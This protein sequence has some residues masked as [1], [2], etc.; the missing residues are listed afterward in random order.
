MIYFSWQVV[1]E[2]IRGNSYT[3]DI[4]LDDISFTVGAANCIQRPYD[5]LP[6]GVTTSAP[7]LSTSSSV[8]PTTIG[9]FV[10]ISIRIEQ[11]KK[12]TKKNK[13]N[14]CYHK[15][16]WS[17]GKSEVLRPFLDMSRIPLL[18]K[19]FSL[20]KYLSTGNSVINLLFHFNSIWLSISGNIG[21]DCNFDVG[22]CKW[23]FASYGQFNWTRHQ[24][25]TA[26]SGT[27]PK[28]D[29]TRGNSGTCSSHV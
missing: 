21:N 16:S 24:G 5:S 11:K 9:K 28:Y 13:E 25:S 18:D 12:K 17:L 10:F 23:T 1:F 22:I 19:H 3:G 27:G 15:P 6:P 7:T 2:G 4:A 20:L 29:H 26:S 14:H 8:A